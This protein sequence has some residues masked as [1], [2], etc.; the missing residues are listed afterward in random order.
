MA[1][2]KIEWDATW[3]DDWQTVKVRLED[4][5]EE[6]HPRNPEQAVQLYRYGFGTARREPVLMWSDVESNLY[7]DYMGGAP[8][9]GMERAPDDLEWEQVREWAQRGWEAAQP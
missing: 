5:L 1:R 3:D 6:E 9:P 7:E 2:P 8:E 4:E